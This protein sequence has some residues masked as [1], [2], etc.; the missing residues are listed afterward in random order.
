MRIITLAASALFLLAPAMAP[1]GAAHAMFFGCD[2]PHYRTSSYSAP[3]VSY[4]SSYRTGSSSYGYL[5][6]S[7]KKK[8]KKPPKEEYLRIAPTR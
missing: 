8:K 4:S 7:S 6:L 2:T 1:L 3:R 5:D